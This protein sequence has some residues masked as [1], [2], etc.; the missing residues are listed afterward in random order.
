MISLISPS[1]DLFVSF[2]LLTVKCTIRDYTCSQPVYLDMYTVW[3]SITTQC[4]DH[5]RLDSVCLHIPSIGIPYIK[6]CDKVSFAGDLF[7]SRFGDCAGWAQ[8][9]STLTAYSNAQL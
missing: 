6:P 1:K 3:L 9:V 4:H 8:A 7:R 2:R 5:K